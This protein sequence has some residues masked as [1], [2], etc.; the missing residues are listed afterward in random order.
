MTPSPHSSWAEF[1]DTAYEQSFGPF[2]EQLTQGTLAEIRKWV[3][4][5]KRI[6]DFGAGTGRLSVP[7]AV[8]G[9]NVTAVDPCQE[10]IQQL[11]RKQ[12]DAGI[13]TKVCRM[14]DFHA[15]EPFDMALCVCTV[16]LYLLDEEAL[17]NS[18]QAAANA[19]RL[20]GLLLVD[21]PSRAIFQS[22]QRHTQEV[23]RSVIVT[24][25]G[26]NLYL[27]EEDTTIRSC[28]DATSY[29]EKFS[30]RYWTTEQIEA[31]LAKY[32]FLMKRG[33]TD[34][35]LGTGSRYFLMA[36]MKSAEQGTAEGR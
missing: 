16:L 30:I 14:Q 34:E 15:D 27:Y 21:I 13:K 33:L 17:E 8:E 26:G 2:Y 5:P 23:E 12:P 18:V 19:L 11:K 3:Q 35:F 32:G 7:L 9:Y 10:M 31:V 22:F 1:Y 28:G 29:T 24:P 20:G 36:K 6:V 4:P 25:Q